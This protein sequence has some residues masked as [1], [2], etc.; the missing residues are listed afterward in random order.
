MSARL[1][2]Y[3]L[4]GDTHTA[5][6][7]SR[8]GS[9]DWLCLP[10]FDSAACFA[11]LLG[12]HRHGYWSLAPRGSRWRARRAYRDD[13]LV[14]ET[15]FSTGSDEVR[16]I[17]CMP[18][19]DKR[20]Q[21]VRRVEGVR[22]RM[23]MRTELAPRY[24]FGRVVPWFR[25][26]GRRWL[27]L[28]G[29]DQLTLDADVELTVS[30]DHVGECEFEVGAGDVVDFRLSWQVPTEPAELPPQALDVGLAIE[31]TERWWREWVGHA[32]SPGQY[33]DAVVRSLITLKALTYAPTGGMVAAP[34]TSLP[35]RLGGVRNWD[36]RFCWLRDAT[37]TLLALLDAGFEREA[38]DWREWLLRAVAGRP[39]Q[40]QILYGVDGTR[41]LPELELDWLPGYAGSRPV[42]T[43]NA[44][45]GQYQLD[46]FGEVMDV[47]HQARAHGIPPEEDAWR[48]QRAFMDFLEGNWRYP[49]H[50][51]WEMRGPRRQFTQS[52]VMA[53]V[54]VD[55]A[56]RAVTD[57][58]LD[59]P[60]QKWKRLR[61]EIF[62]DVCTNGYDAER[63][64]FVQHYGSKAVDASLLMIPNVGFLPA[65]DPRMRGTVAA[66]EKELMVDSLVLR[67]PVSASTS[68][69]D[70]LPT[71]EG[72]FLAC[73]FWLADNY[74]LQGAERKGRDL[75]EHLLDLRNDV[76]LLAEEYDLDEGRLVGNFPQA[77]S[78]IPLVN[79]AFNLAGSAGPAHRRAATGK[80][81]RSRKLPSGRAKVSVRGSLSERTWPG[82]IRAAGA[83]T[84][85]AAAKAYTWVASGSEHRH[86][87]ATHGE[88]FRPR[89]W[90]FSLRSAN[91]SQVECFAE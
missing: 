36:Y 38:R 23:P 7:V 25:Q 33:R 16:L 34:T 20:A 49:D 88:L 12:D 14:L 1:E 4:I 10:R 61:Q 47:L 46:V 13:T 50:G 22:G 89:C 31:S 44:A 17:D 24:D 90:R 71:G 55:R 81:D 91:F 35:E 64:T 9:I 30:S 67:Y 54:A 11:A 15:I 79:T 75:F 86:G 27:A 21:L 2:E 69:V 63:N 74:L 70:A 42:R 76:G 41:W 83:S 58:G 87:R 57:F 85:P 45:A 56:V 19:R 40:M 62:D 8:G 6:L 43:G 18:V 78:H 72:T 52:K 77:L 59:G 66:I 3:A 32:Q 28:A 84:A 51:I 26:R 48:V 29:P 80:I 39:D 68:E 37:L 60:V 65:T 82:R 53:W 5:A 73:G